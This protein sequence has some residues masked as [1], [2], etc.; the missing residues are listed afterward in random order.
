MNW[1]QFNDWLLQQ[2]SLMKLQ[3]NTLVLSLELILK[4]INELPKR[5]KLS[6]TL[7]DFS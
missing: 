5:T 6:L 4:I 7:E 2:M 3:L 1:Y